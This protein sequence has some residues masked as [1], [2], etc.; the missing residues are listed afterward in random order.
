MLISNRIEKHDQAQRRKRAYETT[1]SAHPKDAKGRDSA[2]IDAGVFR[3]L[4][5]RRN[6]EKIMIN[7]EWKQRAVLRIRSVE[8][9][10]GRTLL[11]CKFLLAC[12]SSFALV[13]FVTPNVS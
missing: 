10:S 2:S 8:A 4:M 6:A 12:K 7:L 1:L 11:P 13:T 9:T 3:R 5:V